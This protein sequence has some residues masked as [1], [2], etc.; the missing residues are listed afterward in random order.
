MGSKASVL[1]TLINEAK[2]LAPV[3][4]KSIQEVERQ[5]EREGK[6]FTRGLDVVNQERLLQT[7]DMVIHALPG[8]PVHQVDV[9]L[10]GARHTFMDFAFAGRP[11]SAGVD[12]MGRSD[13]FTL[14]AF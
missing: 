5:L 13:F 10:R 1:L 7:D 2:Q 8:N 14:P 9:W 12:R 6:S 4:G 11:D 3:F